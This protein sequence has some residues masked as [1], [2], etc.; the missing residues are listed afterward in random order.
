MRKELGFVRPYKDHFKHS[1][2]RPTNHEMNS[3]NSFWEANN[4]FIPTKHDG[5]VLLLNIID[6][7]DKAIVSSQIGRSSKS[8]DFMNSEKKLFCTEMLILQNS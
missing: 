7:F 2:K 8:K 5:F 4:K 6:T 1:K 3:P